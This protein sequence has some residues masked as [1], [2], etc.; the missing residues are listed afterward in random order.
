MNQYFPRLRRRSC[1][2]KA[3][4]KG[5]ADP[6]QAEEMVHDLLDHPNSDLMLSNVG[7]VKKSTGLAGFT[8]KI[9]KEKTTMTESKIKASTQHQF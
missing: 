1:Y 9:G 3:L 6:K 8:A 7:I 4:R 5:I 2:S